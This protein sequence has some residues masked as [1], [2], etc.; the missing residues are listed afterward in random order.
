MVLASP[1]RDRSPAQRR[2]ILVAAIAAMGLTSASS[3]LLIPK[4]PPPEQQRAQ[5]YVAALARGDYPAMHAQLTAAARRSRGEGAF[6]DDHRRAAA[7]ATATAF[8]AGEIGEP[9]DGVVSVPMIV[10]TR[11]FGTIRA[12]LRLPFEGEDD[13]ARIDWAP[14][15]TFPG[16]VRGQRLERTLHLP[17]RAD[18]LARD[19]TPLAQGEARTSP[20]G[21]VATAISGS[22]EAAPPERVEELRARGV[23]DDAKVG[24]TGLERVFD[25]QLSG[26]PGGSLRAGSKVLATATPRAGEAVRTSIDPRVQRAAVEALGD[27][28]G[29]IAVLRPGT[30]EILGLSGVAFSGLQPP[31][32][33]FKMITLAGALQARI[34]G[35]N[36]SYP[37]QTRAVLEGVELENANGESC[38]GSLRLSFAH[39]CN[40]VFAP[41]GARLG[42]PRLVATAEAFGFNEDLGHPGRR[43]QHDPRGRPG[44]RRAGGRLDGDRPG[45]GAGDGPDDGLGRGDDR[46]WR[47]AHAADPARRSAAAGAAARRARHGGE[48][49]RALHGGRRAGRHGRRGED[50]RRARGGQDGH[51][52]AEDDPGARLHA[53]GGRRVPAGAGRRPQRH[54]RLVRRLRPGRQAADR[55]RCGADRQRRPAARRPRRWRGRC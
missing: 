14:H 54:G 47:L 45:Q 35:P 16:V 34:A 21:A 30:G 19:G 1:L 7:T 6:A 41:L 55:R 24:T 9:E 51:G 27:Q 12:T 5:R 39:S 50:L 43:D 22:L 2:L 40:S 49:P 8:R 38:G 53:G 46:R 3:L 36:S 42:A 13:K 48:Q 29:G 25:E 37:V 18:I 17:R 15:L 26:R 10:T 20:L 31:G 52:G 11:A 28:Y 4:G 23:P 44:R 32:S 33:T